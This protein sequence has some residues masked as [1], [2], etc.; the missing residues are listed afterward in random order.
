[1]S[2]QSKEPTHAPKGSSHPLAFLAFVGLIP[3]DDLRVMEGL[4]ERDCE[5]IEADDVPDS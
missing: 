4:I 3:A 1:M 5:G 2:K